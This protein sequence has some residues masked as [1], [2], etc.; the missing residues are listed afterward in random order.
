[1]YREPRPVFLESVFLDLI[2]SKI[3]PS[4]KHT[5]E[6][7]GMLVYSSNLKIVLLHGRASLTKQV[8]KVLYWSTIS[9]ITFSIQ[10]MNKFLIPFARTLKLKRKHS[11][12]KKKGRKKEKNENFQL[13]S[14]PLIV[15]WL[16]SDFS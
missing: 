13:V 8:E 16:A 14:F 9:V 12:K 2:L 11:K 5:F 3:F 10:L 15:L 6:T 1:M 4:N 7:F